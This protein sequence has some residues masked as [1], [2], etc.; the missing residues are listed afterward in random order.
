MTLT[1]FLCKNVYF[2]HRRG[3]R[4]QDSHLFVT[5]STSFG[6]NIHIPGSQLSHPEDTT[7][8]LFRYTNQSTAT[9]TADTSLVSCRSIRMI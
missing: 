5:T 8:D 3:F 4:R 2:F 9:A 6:H 7:F 1:F